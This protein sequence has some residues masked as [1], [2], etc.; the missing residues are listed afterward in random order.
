MK[1]LLF[2][3]T[4]RVVNGE[5]A[6]FQRHLERM[7]NTIGEVFSQEPD[8][9]PLQ[10][11]EIPAAAAKC[12]ILYGK[13]IKSTEFS[14]YKPRTINSLK[15]VNADAELDYHLKYADRT[16]LTSLREQREGC[17]EILIVKDG[18]VTDTSYSN[19]VFTD[20]QKFVTPSTYLLPGTMRASLLKSGAI[21]EAPITVDNIMQYTHVALINAMLPLHAMPLIPIAN[22][23]K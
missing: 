18:N 12:R 3:E 10:D 8:L 22:I 6:N 7:R 1:D 20:G 14:D 9:D 17:D 2:I 15:L 11:I 16:M 4:M 21:T 23:C 5:I 13:Q 19:V